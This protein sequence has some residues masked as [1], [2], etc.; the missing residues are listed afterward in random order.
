MLF[1]NRSDA[2]RQLA[3][4]L[5]ALSLKE[6]IVIG[7]PR[8]GVVVAAEVA[9]ILNLP[10]DVIIPRKIGAPFNNELAI[11]AIVEDTVLLN[12]DLISAY[13]IDPAYI[14][15][16]IAKEKIE[17]AR[18]LAL[19]RQGKTKE[20][21]KNKTII[22]VD[23]GI[24]TGATMRASLMYLKSNHVKRLIVAIPVAPPESVEQLKK[25][26]FEVVCL[27][28]PASFFA[29]GQFY[30]DFPQTTDEEVIKL[31]EKLWM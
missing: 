20:N 1:K 21:L 10:L 12:D 24:A 31:M 17:A 6:G 29:V 13:D 19:Y 9:R 11:G 14:Q 8:G 3:A 7:L 26:G 16:E 27:C 25:E 30:E 18:R 15:R 4:A 23:D 5:Q 2:G 28:T 22:V